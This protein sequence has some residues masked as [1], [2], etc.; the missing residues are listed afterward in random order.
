MTLTPNPNSVMMLPG[1][2]YLAT[3]PTSYLPTAYLPTYQLT[4]LP[5]CLPAYLPPT[6]PSPAKI[7]AQYAAL[8][9]TT[10]LP[11]RFALGSH[12]VYVR[13]CVGR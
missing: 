12:Q 11:P 8:T 10:P 9:G 1:T 13:H 6:G 7:F 5:T 2:P 3:S 4:Y